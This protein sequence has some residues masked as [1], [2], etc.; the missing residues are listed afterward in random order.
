MSFASINHYSTLF[1]SQSYVYYK[2][3]NISRKIVVKKLSLE[4]A[5]GFRVVT[6]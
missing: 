6:A 2:H 3:N 5:I 1:S 4:W